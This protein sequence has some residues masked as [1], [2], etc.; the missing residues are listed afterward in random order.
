[1]QLLCFSVV[2]LM[3][4]HSISRSKNHL[5]RRMKWKEI[6]YQKVKSYGRFLKITSYFPFFR[7]HLDVLNSCKNYFTLIHLKRKRRKRKSSEKYWG[8]CWYLSQKM[9]KGREIVDPF[10]SK[11]Y[12][13]NIL[14]WISV[15]QKRTIQER[16]WEKGTIVFSLLIGDP[17]A[18]G[19][20]AI[21]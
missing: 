8:Y 11:W 19:N 20:A 9:L 1:M 18:V 6:F 14:L 17:V 7:P 2:R 5:G 21:C 10:S 3:V 15:S 4:T 13:G 12:L 16:D